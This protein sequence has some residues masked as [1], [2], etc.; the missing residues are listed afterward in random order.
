MESPTYTGLDLGVV[1]VS[2]YVYGGFVP[3]DNGFVATSDFLRLELIVEDPA[4]CQLHHEALLFGVEVQG[5][6]PSPRGYFALLLIDT[7]AASDPTL[8]FLDTK[9]LM[10]QGGV[11]EA[12][13]VC[14]ELHLFNFATCAWLRCQTFAHDYY[15]VRPPP[16][17]DGDVRQF[18][19]EAQVEL[20]QPVA[21][22]FR[23]CHHHALPLVED[24]REYV[25]F[26]GG[27]Y[28]DYL[29]HFDREPYVLDRFDVLRL[30]R[31]LLSPSNCN[32]LRVP[33][34]NLRTKMWLFPRFF[35]NLSAT[36]AP[37]AMAML[38]EN[39]ALRDARFSFYGG[40][41]LIAGK[42]ITICHGLVEF[43]PEKAEHFGALK[44]Q[45]QTET[46]FLGAHC[47]LTFPSL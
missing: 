30:T 35:Y 17:A 26:I 6:A 20:P 38:R 23:A 43:V 12:Y 22:E 5:E 24:G 11:N 1:S 14:P 18:S 3:R 31:L 42:Q 19:M 28:N 41:A 9:S 47:R 33:V 25:V 10:V 32:L 27:F 21:A 36:V 45:L 13:E 15:G 40:A 16:G 2:V 46:I 29:R 34:L 8:R 7:S 39:E 37:K 44:R 4:R